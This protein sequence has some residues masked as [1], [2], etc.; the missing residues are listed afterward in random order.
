MLVQRALKEGPFSMRQLA[1]TMMLSYGVLRAWAMGRRTPKPD[2]LEQL[3]AGFEKRAAILT[4]LAAE[5]RQAAGPTSDLP[6]SQSPTN[7]GTDH[8]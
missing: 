2:N 8:A 5:L 3:A 7:P 6:S 4:D 1:E